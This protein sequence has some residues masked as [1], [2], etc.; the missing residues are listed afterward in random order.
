VKDKQ[1]I[2]KTNDHSGRK[3][4]PTTP[5]SGRNSLP[6]GYQDGDG[7]DQ[8]PVDPLVIPKSKAGI[9]W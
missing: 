8:F 1:T 9:P 3:S 6:A 4:C 2:L 7:I 5:T